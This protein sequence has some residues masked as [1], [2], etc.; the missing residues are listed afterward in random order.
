MEKG[1]RDGEG[2]PGQGRAMDIQLV[3]SNLL[4][5]RG[6]LLCTPSDTHAHTQ[7]EATSI[8]FHLLFLFLAR[9]CCTFAFLCT[10]AGRAPEGASAPKAMTYDMRSIFLNIVGAPFERTACGS[11][12][13]KLLRHGSHHSNRETTHLKTDTNL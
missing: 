13:S 3:S 4:V 8:S 5:K 1:H 12:F 9:P 11:S 2:A 10:P 7:H 6:F